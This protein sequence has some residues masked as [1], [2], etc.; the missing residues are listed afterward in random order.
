[1]MKRLPILFLL[2][3]CAC[4]RSAPAEYAL[5]LRILPAAPFTRSAA[6]E[7]EQRISDYN[8]LIYNCFGMLEDRFYCSWR[9]TDEPIR[10]DTQLLRGAP[11]TILVAANLG[12]RLPAPATLEEA[13]RLRHYLAYPDEY[14]LGLP[15]AVR[16]DGCLPE[17]E[18][19][20]EVRLERLMARIDLEIDR[21]A[22]DADVRFTVQSVA[23]GGCPSSVQLFGPSAA[24]TAADV[25]TDGFVLSGAAAAVLNR[26]VTLGHSQTASLYL[27][28]NRQGDLLEHVET[29]AGKVF[30]EG[31]Y[32]EVCSYIEIRAEY[33]SDSWDSRAGAPLIYRFYLGENRNNFDVRRNCVYRIT[34]RPEGDGLREDSWR[35]DKEGLVPRRRLQLYPAAYN[36]CQPG[37]DFHIWCEV[38]PRGAP[39][40]IEPLAW[41]DDE[42]VEQLYD[43]TLDADGYGLTLHT[44]KG[45]SALVYFRAGPPVDRD[46]LAMLVIG[47]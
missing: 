27:L 14:S 23:V 33:H 18:G 32:R 19:P 36:E 2:L 4:M 29:D 7:D 15:M 13:E 45:G 28:E 34:V 47:P 24:G 11:F 39:M 25:F 31:R 40:T 16:L 3:L 41:D 21:T 26:E 17:Q 22:L 42:R 37:E 30:T 43:Y 1:M 12:Y 6:P 8:I 46:T 10:Y 38:F 44:K 5:A 20:L 35:V 9:D